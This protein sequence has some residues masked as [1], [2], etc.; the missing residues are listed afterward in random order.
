MLGIPCQSAQFV[1]DRDI[2]ILEVHTPIF[3]RWLDADQ[4]WKALFKTSLLLERCRNLK[5]KK[6][7]N[8]SGLHT[9]N[10]A[11]CHVSRM[12]TLSLEH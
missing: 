1:A 11:L 2:F 8:I 3:S 9:S 5:K 12:I 4:I 6:Y 7:P 10:H